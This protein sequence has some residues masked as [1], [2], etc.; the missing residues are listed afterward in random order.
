MITGT[1]SAA[2][3]RWTCLW[4]TRGRRGGGSGRRG[5]RSR[6]V[7]TGG[8]RFEKAPESGAARTTGRRRAARGRTVG[9]GRR[10]VPSRSGGAARARARG[11][12]RGT[13]GDARRTCCWF[14]E[15][16]GWPPSRSN[17]R[18]APSR[19]ESLPRAARAGSGDLASRGF[20]DREAPASSASPPTRAPASLGVAR[21][22]SS[23]HG[24]CARRRAR[25]GRLP[26]RGSALPGPARA[27]D[28]RAAPGIIA[29]ARLAVAVA[30]RG[31]GSPARRP[32]PSRRRVRARR[33]PPRATRRPPRR[34]SL[35]ARLA[36]RR[37]ARDRGGGRAP[38][39]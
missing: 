25:R 27:R 12:P 11:S 18:R 38:L 3:S 1:A 8:G 9:G 24:A 14:F 22:R 35:R 37:G 36:N 34:P 2:R 26:R 39:G 23:A 17:A 30:S 6:E 33:S 20:V 28:R 19:L 10:R 16:K 15:R 31:G 21:A 5:E 7:G 29:A 13:C 4:R 32:P